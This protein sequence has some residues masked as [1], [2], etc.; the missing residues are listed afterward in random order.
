MLALKRWKSFANGKVY[1]LETED[2][3]PIEVTDTFWPNSYV[4]CL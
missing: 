2:G 3:Y 4:G 1:A